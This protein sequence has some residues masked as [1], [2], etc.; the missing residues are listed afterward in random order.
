MLTQFDV[1]LFFIAPV[2][3]L[4][5]MIRFVANMLHDRRQ[6]IKSK[7]FW[8]CIK[9]GE[10]PETPPIYFQCDW[11]SGKIISSY[12]D[13]GEMIQTKRFQKQLEQAKKLFAQKD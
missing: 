5:L 10:I 6:R 1:V 3:I 9:A 2:L 13:P 12:I 7:N 11:W 4:V 8:A